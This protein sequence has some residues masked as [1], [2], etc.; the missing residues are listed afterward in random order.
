MTYKTA[1]GSLSVSERKKIN[2]R[3]RLVKAAH[4]VMSRKGIGGATIEEITERAEVGIGTFYNYFESKDDLACQ[5]LDCI[6]I[7]LGKRNDEATMAFK[8]SDPALVQAVSIRLTIREMLRSMIWRWWFNR[9][10]LLVDRMRI[11]FRPFGVRDLRI[12]VE[13]GSYQL[14]LSQIEAVWSQ[15][16]WMLVGGVSDILKS[17]VKELDESSLIQTIMRAMGVSAE[18]SLEVSQ[19]ELPEVRRASIDFSY[20]IE[21][22]DFS[23]PEITER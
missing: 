9:Q 19:L 20:V 2:T 8:D 5:V 4:D 15:Q 12:G 21:V 16:M 1:Q 23:Q 7:D 3:Q 6:I 10:D 17:K 22:S 13:T 18:R 14:D 11:G